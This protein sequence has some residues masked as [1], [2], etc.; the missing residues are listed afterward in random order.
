MFD[1]Q[2]LKFQHIFGLQG[3]VKNNVHFVEEGVIIY[4]SGASTVV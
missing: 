2:T 1:S 3:A 4:P